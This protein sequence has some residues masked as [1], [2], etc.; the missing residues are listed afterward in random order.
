VASRVTLESELIALPSGETPLL[1]YSATVST[2]N[3]GRFATV[4]PPGRYRVTVEPLEGTGFASFRQEIIIE[5][6]T[7]ITLSPPRRTRVRGVALLSD[8]RP[9]A[10]AEVVATAEPL[11]ETTA[12]PSP[13]PARANVGDDG[14]F[15][16]DL[17]QG[18]YVL[19]IVPE[20][21]T[22]FPRVVTRATIAPDQADVGVVRIPPPTRLSLQIVDPTTLARPIPLANVR[23]F[24]RPE[25]GQ[26]AGQGPGQGP[27]L[28][29]GSG[30]TNAEGRVEIL[31]AQQPK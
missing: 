24:A 9:A 7:P 11:A 29:I 8:G 25:G 26:G 23:I 12:Q 27:L 16:L 18:A 31:L 22:G 15:A 17:D 6:D 1:E 3:R 19:T 10:K 20:E 4:V 13:R 28:E 5:D 14:T 2:D 30:M 21:G